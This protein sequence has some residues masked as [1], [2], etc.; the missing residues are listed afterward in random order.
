MALTW[1]LTLYSSYD[2]LSKHSPAYQVPVNF[3][4]CS[5]EAQSYSNSLPQLQLDDCLK[6]WESLKHAFIYKNPCNATSEDYQPLMELT[7]H[8]IPC[9]KFAE[10]ACGVVQVMLN[11]S[12]E[13]GAFRS[14][15]IF[16]SIE[17]F[18]LNPDKVSAVHIWLMHD[19]G[20]PQRKAIVFFLNIFNNL[21][22]CQPS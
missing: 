17:V 11:G 9:N 8:P 4:Y 21:V 22:P 13:A 3:S 16:G 6:I 14:N 19:I 10:A 1:K 15:S 18:N 5:Q 7:S 20:G 2:P 12:I